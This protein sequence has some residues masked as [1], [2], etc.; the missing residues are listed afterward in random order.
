MS[1]RKHL[2]EADREFYIEEANKILIG[3]KTDTDGIVN[4][5]FLMLDNLKN[6]VHVMGKTGKGKSSFIFTLIH[7]VK[8]IKDTTIWVIDPHGD[9]LKDLFRAISNHKNIVYLN[10][11]NQ[12][13]IFGFNPVFMRGK[14]EHQK[15]AVID[16]ILDIIQSETEEKTGQST[17]GNTTYIR[18][19][20]ML[21][22][23]VEFADAYYQ[24]LITLHEREPNI[25][26]IDP[27]RAEELVKERQITLNDIPFFLHKKMGYYHLFTEVFR[28][29][30][31]LTTP[32]IIK[33]FEEYTNQVAVIE[34]VQV[35]FDQLLHSSTMLIYEGNS[36]PLEKAVE[37]GNMYLIPIPNTIYG[38]RGARGL[39][40]ILFS[41]LWI[42]K[43]E[44]GKK[45]RRPTYLFIDEFQNAQ[46]ATIPTILSE[47][48]KYKLYLITAHQY[49]AQLKD[50]IREAIFGT[51]GTLVAFQSGADK[52]G[53]LDIAKNLGGGLTEE[54][55]VSLPKY[56]AYIKTDGKDENSN[57]IFSFNT[58]PV[59]EKNVSQSQIDNIN[60]ESLEKYGEDV[61]AIKERL[62]K[63][64]KDPLNYF[65]EGV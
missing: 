14:S 30:S 65:T 31:S 20:Q 10:I 47:A 27:K 35:R 60:A 32:S 40:Q 12:K 15:S 3:T 23:A 46:L 45:D 19:K 11:E 33:M 9:L 55:I 52:N 1:R 37:D 62:A 25:K 29:Y 39:L 21:T 64:Q 13:R 6:H 2:S 8:K 36:L 44:K 28:D 16:T 43:E 38:S 17:T 61:A 26:Q 58:I 4:K 34:A 18:M 7:A 53:A 5:I 59:E 49:I 56:T 50:K 41:M 24:Y 51:V 48:R 54:D 42:Y 63:K 22:L 57:N